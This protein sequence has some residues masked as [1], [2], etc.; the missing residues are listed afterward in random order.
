[1]LVI[2]ALS[3]VVA[4]ATAVLRIAP[5]NDAWETLQ[6]AKTG[7]LSISAHL[8]DPALPDVPFLDWLQN[9][10]GSDGRVSMG[11]YSSCG[12]GVRS[13]R[14]PDDF[15]TP[16][17]VCAL[18][19]VTLPDDRTVS[20]ALAA[21]VVRDRDRQGEW[22]PRGAHLTNAYVVDG[23]PGPR[24]LDSLDVAS[25]PELSRALTIPV[26]SWPHADLRVA[27]EDLRIEPPSFEARQRVSVVVTIHNV[28]SAS[29]RARLNVQGRPQCSEFTATA[30]G[31]AVD[32]DVPARGA[33][34]FRLAMTTPDAPR[35]LL[36]AHVEVLP[37]AQMIR[38][39]DASGPVIKGAAKAIGPH[40][41]PTCTV[42]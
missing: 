18:V 4:A 30:P 28:G 27:P 10:V 8:I 32:G 12:R 40:P 22:K 15:E 16:W 20:L 11:G 7:A 19:T 6:R 9:T 37:A 29:A 25:L 36:E 23:R 39:Y 17:N 33:V 42:R 34:T 35:W 2:T 21:S 41:F 13:A 5:Q 38:K 1:M 3:F 24:H 26:A 14:P 31:A